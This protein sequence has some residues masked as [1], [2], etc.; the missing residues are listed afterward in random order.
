MIISKTP[1]RISFFGGGTDY[2]KWYSSKNNVGKVL[3]VTINKYSYIVLRYLP[4]FFNYKYRIRYYKREETKTLN[5]IQHPTVREVLKLLK[6]KEGVELV[7]HADLP[8]RSGLGSSSTFTVG[9]L[10]V[11]Y[12]LKKKKITKKLLASEAIFVEQN[13]LNERVGSQDQIA[14][15]YGGFNK[16]TF[17]EKKPDNSFV[18][19]KIDC[20]NQKIKNLENNLL[21][22]FTGLV[23]TADLIVKDQLNQIEKNE[24]CLNEM[25]QIVDY[26][27]KILR[28]NNLQIK[29][30][31]KLLDLQWKLKK[32]LSKNISNSKID[33]YYN[34]GI[35]A[36]AIGGKL[37][38]AGSGGFLLFYVEKEKQEQV[39]K[40]LSSILHVPFKF[41]KF[42]S[43]ILYN[44]PQ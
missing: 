39:K 28:S 12:A 15:S 9:L 37:L 21:L 18:V 25:V 35:E 42:G 30:F 10:N 20:S 4:P 5:Q 11:L 36:G 31:G 26:G 22:F 27:E 41:E 34:L 13:L 29:E 8:A 14:A 19:K 24:T 38:G 2:P 33:R 7:H 32:S 17:S 44:Q 23:R 3:S 6:I 1:F 40:N 43:C 16:I